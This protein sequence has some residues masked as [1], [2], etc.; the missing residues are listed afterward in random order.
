MTNKRQKPI[1]DEEDLRKFQN[2]IG[3]RFYNKNYLLHALTHGSVNINKSYERLEFLG[4][5]VLSII[6]TEYL[7]TQFPNIKEGKL[8]KIKSFLISGNHIAHVGKNIEIGNI[9]ILSKAE[10]ENGGRDKPKLIE[11][12]VESLIGAI[13]L[14]SNLSLT[15]LRQVIL[16]LWKNFLDDIHEAIIDPKGFIQEYCQSYKSLGHAYEIVE[17]R[18]LAHDMVFTAKLRVGNN[19]TYQE[20]KSKKDAEKNAAIAMIIFL[21]DDLYISDTTLSFL[22]S[23]LDNNINK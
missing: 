17:T 9:L 1:I 19:T 6:I 7:Y 15:P 13:Y 12:S 23:M 10:E 8:S 16:L 21:A 22:K 5:S 2:R 3:Y 18:G 11:N 14:D 4:D 20:G